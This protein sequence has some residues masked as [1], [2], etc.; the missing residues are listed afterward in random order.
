MEKKLNTDKEEECTVIKEFET[1]NEIDISFGRFS[2]MG[3]SWNGK[4]MADIWRM[5]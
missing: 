2:E 3:H 5:I 4:P 1:L